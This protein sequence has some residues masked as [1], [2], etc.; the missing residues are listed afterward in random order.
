M[1]SLSSASSRMMSGVN[2]GG[3]KLSAWASCLSPSSD[4]MAQVLYDSLQYAVLR[5]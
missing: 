1:T 2:G 5:R 4:M 3:W